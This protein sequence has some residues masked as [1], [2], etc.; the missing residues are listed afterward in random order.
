MFVRAYEYVNKLLEN[1]YSPLFHH[2]DTVCFLLLLAVY[3]FETIAY[4]FCSTMNICVEAGCQHMHQKFQLKS[5]CFNKNLC[6]S[7]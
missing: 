4:F 3:D 2:S 5:M 7:V 1:T 6:L